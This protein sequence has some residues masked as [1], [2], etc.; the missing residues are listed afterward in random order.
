MIKGPW[1]FIFG[2]IKDQVTPETQSITKIELLLGP[3]QHF[4]EN[5]IKYQNFSQLLC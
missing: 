2:K 5:L 4:R 1:P 3:S